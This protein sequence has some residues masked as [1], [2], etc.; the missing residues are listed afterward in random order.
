MH[1]QIRSQLIWI[2]PVCK[3]RAYPGSARLGLIALSLM[4]KLAFLFSSIIAPD[5]VIIVVIIWDN[6]NVIFLPKHILWYSLGLFWQG[7]INWS[8]R[9]WQLDA[10]PNGDQEFASSILAGSATFFRGDWSWNIFYG[11]ALPSLIKKGS[12]QF[13]AKE[14]AQYWLTT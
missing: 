13:L 7:D 5:K 2:Y 3:C 6:S 1:I 4:W 8:L 12:C 14:C 9:L 10:R 11:H